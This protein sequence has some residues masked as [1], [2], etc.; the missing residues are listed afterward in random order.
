MNNLFKRLSPSGHRV[1][2]AWGGRGP[3]PRRQ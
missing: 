2:T 1:V 3:R